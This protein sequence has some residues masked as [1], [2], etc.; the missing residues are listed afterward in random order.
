MTLSE[1]LDGKKT[2]I[3]IITM[4]AGLFLAPD[5]V[6]LLGI[7]LD[8]VFGAVGAIIAV[9]GRMVTK[10]GTTVPPPPQD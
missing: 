3:G 5:Q 10:R 4:A 2:Y 9:Y 1:I 7:A 8:Q 6:E